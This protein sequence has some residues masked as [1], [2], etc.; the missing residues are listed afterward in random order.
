MRDQ[1]FFFHS[2]TPHSCYVLYF[3]IFLIFS[4]MRIFQK[5]L[6]IGRLGCHMAEKFL[7]LKLDILI[8]IHPKFYIKTVFSHKVITIG[9]I[10]AKNPTNFLKKNYIAKQTKHLIIQDLVNCSVIN[11][12]YRPLF[13]AYIKSF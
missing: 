11:V 4:K 9:D 2:V 1:N 7:V 13:M 12:Q 3:V 10:G 8:Y 6:H 5:F